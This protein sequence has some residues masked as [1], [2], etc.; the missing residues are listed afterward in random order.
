MNIK[1]TMG[2]LSLG[3]KALLK[4]VMTGLESCLFTEVL[5]GAVVSGGSSIQLGVGSRVNT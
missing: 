4:K 2:L 5:K 3:C 1:L